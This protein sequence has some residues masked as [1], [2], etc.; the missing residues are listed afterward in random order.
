MSRY[1][2]LGGGVAAGYA[3]KEMVERGLGPG[4]LTI[5]SL[6]TNVPY[7][8]PPLSKGFLT[9]DKPETDVLIAPDSFYREHGIDLR[10]EAVATCIDFDHRQLHLASG[11]ELPFDRLLIATGSAVRKLTVAGHDL[12]GILYLRSLADAKRIVSEA[13]H[14]TRA[15]VAGSGFIGMEVA[16]G[17]AKRG[18]ETTLLFPEARVW[19]RLFTPEIS[20]FFEQYYREQDVA[21]RRE[22]GVSS[23]EGSDG[24][25]RS[26]NTTRG[27]RI[28]TDVV[29]A[30]IGVVPNTRSLEGAG[31]HIDDGVVVNEYLETSV[32]GVWAAGDV[33]RYLD[34]RTG[35]HRRLEHWDNAVEQGKHAARAML[36]QR[37]AFTHV[38]YFFSDVFDLSYE[39][40]GDTDGSS[41][42]L[43]RGDPTTRSFSA[44][45][46]RDGVVVGAFIMNRPAE[47]RD[48]APRWIAEGR[49]IATAALSNAGHALST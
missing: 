1:L 3:A 47:E 23:F 45:W 26:V 31:L 24:R 38:P 18:M 25:V 10:L 29:V 39:F 41:E 9:G 30:G 49:R 19:E 28:K 36:G 44:W 14:A 17:L 48:A 46:L 42:V 32:D 5:V 27:Q 7:D 12:L 13:G 15:T 37:E 11:E 20:R 35:K 40:W 21:L 34:V 43:Y 22:E 16:A 4:E 2:I 33:A 6:D 8:R